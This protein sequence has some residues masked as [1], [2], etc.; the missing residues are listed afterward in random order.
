MAGYSLQSTGKSDN[1]LALFV[2]TPFPKAKCLGLF[3]KSSCRMGVE[4]YHVV[5]L[6]GEGSFGKVYKGRRKYTRQTV[7]MKFILKYGKS[8][9]DR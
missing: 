4:N 5:E 9:K 3:L 1:V 6:V 8:E 7:A 2:A